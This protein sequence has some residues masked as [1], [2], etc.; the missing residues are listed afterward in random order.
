MRKAPLALLMAVMVMATAAFI[1]VRPD[2]PPRSDL[3]AV[4]H[5]GVSYQREARTA[6]RPLMIHVIEVDLSA[7]GVGLLVTPGGT[8][9]GMDVPPRTTS[10]FLAE[11]GVQVAVN[12]AFFEPARGPLPEGGTI[13]GDDLLDVWG[14]A[15]SDGQVYSSDHPRFPVFCFVGARAQVARSGCPEETQHA[16]AGSPLLLE[17]GEPARSSIAR[18]RR[19]LHPRTAVAV[20]QAGDRLWLIV[21]DGR[22][23]NYSEGVT[24]DELAQIALDLGAYDAVNLDGGGSTTLVVE[25]RDGPKVLNSPI[26]RRIPLRQRPVGNHLGVYAQPLAGQ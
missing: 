16:L 14:L 10:Q 6:P 19:A 24:L 22:Q 7:P 20:N 2:R 8:G 12:G 1:A 17:N 18:Y 25:G 5:E 15:I 11:F 4:L 21:V 13:L 3:T 23:R 26:H 9:P